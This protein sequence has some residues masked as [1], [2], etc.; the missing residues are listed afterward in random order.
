[1][2]IDPQATAAEI[3][4]ICYSSALGEALDG[5][6]DGEVLLEIGF[7]LTQVA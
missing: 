3:L 2:G 1:M 6:D 7:V 4:I 5:V